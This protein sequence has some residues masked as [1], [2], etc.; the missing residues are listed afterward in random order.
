MFDVSRAYRWVLSRLFA[1]APAAP[2]AVT[3]ASTE[4]G[5]RVTWIPGGRTGRHN[6]EE[7]EHVVSVRF[8]DGAGRE[9]TEGMWMD[10]YVGTARSFELKTPRGGD[11]ARLEARVRAENAGGTSA[12]VLAEGEGARAT[13]GNGDDDWGTQWKKQSS[14][15]SAGQ[16]V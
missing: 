3:M 12:W 1:V 15:A 13:V 5:V 10:V 7:E 8:A 9:A 6:L 4:A 14:G 16:S 2:R 11:G